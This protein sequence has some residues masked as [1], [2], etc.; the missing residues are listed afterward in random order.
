MIYMYKY[1][2][3]Y[4]YTSYHNVCK[5]M[6]SPFP[7]IPLFPLEV[8]FGAFFAILAVAR[9]HLQAEKPGAVGRVL[10]GPRSKCRCP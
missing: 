2:Y 3:M 5:T 4:I 10:K 1:I 8:F 9:L 6:S 7:I